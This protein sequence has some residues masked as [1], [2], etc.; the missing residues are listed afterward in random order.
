MLDMGIFF[1]FGRMAV[2]LAAVRGKSFRVKCAN[3]SGTRPTN[4]R[5]SLELPAMELH[6]MACTIEASSRRLSSCWRLRSSHTDTVDRYD[7]VRSCELC[8]AENVSPVVREA[9]RQKAARQ[10]ARLLEQLSAF[11]VHRHRSASDGTHELFLRAP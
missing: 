10:R 9:S 7:T 1:V 4:G 3:K 11:A 8:H 5:G 6:R 2:R